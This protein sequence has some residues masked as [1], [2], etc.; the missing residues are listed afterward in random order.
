MKIFKLANAELKKI[1]FRPIMWVVFFVLV[2]SLVLLSFIFKPQEKS[3]STIFFGGLNVQDCYDE[4]L[5]D[6]NANG[7]TKL[8]Q[9]LIETKE[10]LTQK[11]S[12]A[13]NDAQLNKLKDFI[14]FAENAMTQLNLTT[15]KFYKSPK[16]ATVNDVKLCFYNLQQKSNDVL[17]ILT[18][19]R[20]NIAF[21]ISTE[22]FETINTFFTRISKNIPNTFANPEKQFSEINNYLLNNF[23]FNSISSITLNLKSFPVSNDAMEDTFYN[24]YYNIL[25]TNNTNSS[26][27]LNLI[28]KDI[29]EYVAVNSTKTEPLY[30]KEINSLFSKYKSVVNMSCKVLQDKYKLLSSSN[31]SDKEI[32]NYISFEYFDAYNTKQELTKNTFLISNSLYDYEFLDP[33]SFNTCSGQTKNAFDFTIFAMQILTIIIAIFAI[34]IAGS[35]IAGEYNSGTLKML[36][37]RPYSRSKIVISKFLSCVLFTIIILTLAFVS[38]LLVGLISYGTSITKVLVVFN[39]SKV[40]V[41]NAYVLLFVYFISLLLNLIFYISLA[42]LLSTVFKS[43]TLSVLTSFIVYLVGF[44]TSSLLYSKAWFAIL[45]FAHLD[46]YKYFGVVANTGFLGFNITIGT[47]ITFSLLYIIIASIIFLLSSTFIFRK[48]NIA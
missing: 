10:Q 38:S 16:E 44:L 5:N 45:P 29:N 13:E 39:A 24:Y 31:I 35:T 48:R 2:G 36:A 3:N 18:E 41:M 11:I 23:N 14:A 22:N 33:F 20:N 19:I 34:F 46:F 32:A 8:D 17:N 30:L 27:K 6:N 7:K 47:N 26:S 28:F 42:L 9:M 37:I 21:Y 25:D 40:V 15:V 4:F 12:L 1:F 43:S